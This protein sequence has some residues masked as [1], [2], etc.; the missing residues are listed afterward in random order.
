[1][2]AGQ[3]GV[4]VAGKPQTAGESGHALNRRGLGK[5]GRIPGLATSGP[6]Y[7]EAPDDAAQAP[8][9]RPPVAESQPCSMVMDACVG[10]IRRPSVAQTA[11]SET[12]AELGPQ[13]WELPDIWWLPHGHVSVCCGGVPA[14]P[15][16]VVR[17]LEPRLNNAITQTQKN[18]SIFGQIH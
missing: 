1:M 13:T 16:R 8:G 12:R 5:L 3:T 14:L 4:W 11:G 9:R 10:A 17:W 2:T 7:P 15:G 6:D 18:D